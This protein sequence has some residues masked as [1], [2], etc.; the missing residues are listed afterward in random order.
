MPKP[1]RKRRIANKV[2]ERP[3][4]SSTAGLAVAIVTIAQTLGIEGI[5]EPGVSAVIVA[6][7]FVPVIVTGLVEWVRKLASAAE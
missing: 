1:K 6:V 2:A 4:E 3:A 5:D 7:G